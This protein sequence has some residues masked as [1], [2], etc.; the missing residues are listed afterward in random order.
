MSLT[1]RLA[2]RPWGAR[3]RRKYAVL[4]QSVESRRRLPQLVYD[5][6]ARRQGG[7][8]RQT[9][10]AEQSQFHCMMSR[11]HRSGP[12]WKTPRNSGLCTATAR[13]AMTTRSTARTGE[14]LPCPGNNLRRHCSRTHRHASPHHRVTP[15]QWSLSLDMSQRRDN[16]MTDD[17]PVSDLARH[18]YQASIASPRLSAGPSWEADA[19]VVAAN[20]QTSAA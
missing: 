4:V 8:H 9:V 18:V 1:A 14:M 19:L 7:G 5:F 10:R 17:R 3:A 20:R 11:S 6:H 15:F 12:V 13:P 16:Q 2:R